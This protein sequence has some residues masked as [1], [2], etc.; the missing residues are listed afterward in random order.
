[1]S[2]PAKEGEPILNDAGTA[3]LDTNDHT[4]RDT[5]GANDVGMYLR[6]KVTYEDRRGNRKKAEAVSPYPV[7][8]AIV[9]RNTLPEF[10][11]PDA[12]RSV[13]ENTPL[14]TAIGRPVTAIDPDDEKLSYSLVDA[15]G[16][17]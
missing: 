14:G 4:P 16:A 2:D 8:A 1:M 13:N 12:E 17:Q 5:A 15:E 7:L 6:V 3:E 9:N 11:A 10:G